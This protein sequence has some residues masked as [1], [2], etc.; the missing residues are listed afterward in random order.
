MKLAKNGEIGL[1]CEP[2]ALMTLAEYIMDYGD[3]EL[4]AVG[5]EFVLNHAE[6]IKNQTVKG[7]LKENIQKIING[8]RDLFF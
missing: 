6:T 8:E 1:I 4:M 2:N 3:K 7:K 5:L